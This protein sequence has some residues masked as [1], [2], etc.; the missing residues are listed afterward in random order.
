ML[1]KT[2][3]H[4]SNLENLKLK[5]L[6]KKNFNLNSVRYR[7]KEQSLTIKFNYYKDFFNKQITNLRETDEY[8]NEIPPLYDENTLQVYKQNLIQHILE[9]PLFKEEKK[10]ANK[11]RHSR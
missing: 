3:E 1:A 2:E 7:N 9:T 10:V 11:V 6:W 5:Y 8:L 4:E